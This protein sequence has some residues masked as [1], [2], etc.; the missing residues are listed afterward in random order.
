MIV[1]DISAA[2]GVAAPDVRTVLGLLC[3]LLAKTCF[4]PAAVIR[5]GKAPG[6]GQIPVP[7]LL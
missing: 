2:S 5:E 3:T 7:R 6:S 4:H 1:R